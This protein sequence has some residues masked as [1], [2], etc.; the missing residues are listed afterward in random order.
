MIKDNYQKWFQSYVEKYGDIPEIA[1]KRTH[2]LRVAT[3]MEHV[4]KLLKFSEDYTVLANFVG[5]FHDIGRFEQWR[6]YNTFNDNKSVDHADYSADKLIKDGL[7]SEIISIRDY[8]K[9]IYDA[10]KYHNKLFL[11]NNLN[12]KN[13]QIFQNNL[14]LNTAIKDNYRALT[15]L[16]SMAIRD[17]DKIDILYQYLLSNYFLNTDNLPVTDK[18]AENFF[19]NQ[20]ID[21]RDRKNLN[22]ALVLRLSFINDINLTKSLVLIKNND[23]INKI[24]SV[25]PDKNNMTKF[26]IYAE[27]RLNQLIED[28][29]NHEYVLKK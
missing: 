3:Q 6:N 4:F 21:K 2:S 25:Y 28:N 18:V 22:D 10:I 23:F 12:I 1:L 20:I 8:D 5:L 26:F 17:I 13:E 11:P 29:Y 27:D 24:R 7:I 14:D 16:Y 15:S 19:N 9:L